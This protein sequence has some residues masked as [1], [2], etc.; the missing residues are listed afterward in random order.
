MP[1]QKNLEKN[2][3][4]ANE[5]FKR[6][7]KLQKK[8]SGNAADNDIFFEAHSS[9]IKAYLRV[10]PRDRNNNPRVDRKFIEMLQ[11]YNDWRRRLGQR[12]G[13]NQ[14]PEQLEDEDAQ[15]AA[16]RGFRNAVDTG[17]GS[18]N[19]PQGL[20]RENQTRVNSKQKEKLREIAF[21][22]QTGR[23]C[24]FI[25][26]LK[27]ICMTTIQWKIFTNPSPIYRIR[28]PFGNI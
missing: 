20:S 16:A 6:Q 14:A 15:E 17:A 12:P 26:K 9:L 7:K 24:L 21:A 2:F 27:K 5:V 25:I 4:K 3:E 18:L 22:K 28:R 8:M 10:Q 13:N 23:S 1:D 11:S 19:V